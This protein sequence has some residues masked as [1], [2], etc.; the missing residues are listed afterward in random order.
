MMLSRWPSTDL[1]PSARHHTMS[2]NVPGSMTTFRPTVR[3]V[4]RYQVYR[5]PA[6]ILSRQPPVTILAARPPPPNVEVLQFDTRR[7]AAFRKATPTTPHALGHAVNIMQLH[8]ATMPHSVRNHVIPVA[9]P[10]PKAPQTLPVPHVAGTQQG[11]FSGGTKCG[12]TVK[13]GQICIKGP[14]RDLLKFKNM[15]CFREDVTFV[16]EEFNSGRLI[17]IDFDKTL[18]EIFLWAELGGMGGAEVQLKNLQR[19]HQIGWLLSSFGGQERIQKI[20]KVLELCKQRGDLIC[21]LSSGFAEVIQPALRMMKLDDL[22]PDELVYGSDTWP[23]GI[24]KSGRLAHLKRQHN[25][26]MATLIDDDLG[27]CKAAIRDGHDVIWVK[28]GAGAQK[29]ELDALVNRQW[30]QMEFLTY[31]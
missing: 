25:R 31:L 15:L 8:T 17:A 10:A 7:M 6:M 2:T 27:Y 9:A 30:D 26:P 1:Y 4:T 16:E 12:I 29:R 28:G 13:D 3:H 11:S 18:A 21:V 14:A 23:F 5:P 19:W 20:R 24:S 22:I